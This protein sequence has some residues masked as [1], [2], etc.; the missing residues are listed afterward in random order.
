MAT[1]S[2]IFHSHELM[3]DISLFLDHPE[4]LKYLCSSGEL[5]F[6]KYNIFVF[7]GIFKGFGKISK[8][9]VEKVA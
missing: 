1:F 3:C 7:D 5:D 9:K 6:T 2:D 4:S 8:K